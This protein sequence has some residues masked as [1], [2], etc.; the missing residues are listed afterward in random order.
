MRSIKALFLFMTFCLYT[1]APVTNGDTGGVLPPDPGEAGK[2][3]LIGIDSDGD[4]LRD[5]IQRY[6]YLNYPDQ[7]NVQNAL[8]Q[9][10]IT[11]QKTLDPER[12]VGTGRALA[13]E[14]DLDLECLSYFVDEGFYEMAMK[15]KA[16]IVN[17]YDRAQQYLTFDKELSGG[18]FSGSK[19][20]YAERYK[21][22]N[23]ELELPVKA[24]Y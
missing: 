22:C 12:E 13:N 15:L 8:R 19:L 11:F 20:P 5:D 24:K 6:I 16:E 14:I 21:H 7:P 17:T 9:R 4:G 2:K 18:I 3:T 1:V 10:S 23:F